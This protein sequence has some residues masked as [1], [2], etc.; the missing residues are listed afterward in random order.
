MTIDDFG[1]GYSSLVLLA[2]AA[3]DAIKIDRS[4]V[5]GM[6]NNQEDAAI[7]SS[8]VGLADSLGLDVVAEGVETAETLE[9]LR[10]MGCQQAQGYH[11]CRPRPPRS[12]ATGSAAA[13]FV[14]VP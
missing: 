11:M 4:F 9:M 8:T 7:V 5:L 12:S 10:A 6:H 14:S 13:G 2:P 1:T 3:V